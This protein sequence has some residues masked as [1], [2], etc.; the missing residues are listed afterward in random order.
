MILSSYGL[1]RFGLAV[2][3]VGANRLRVVTSAENFKLR[4]LTFFAVSPP[5]R[6]DTEYED[7]G[8]VKEEVFIAVGQCPVLL[9]M[10]LCPASY[11]TRTKTARGFKFEAVSV[12][13]CKST[14]PPLPGTLDPRHRTC[15]LLQSA[16]QPS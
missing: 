8:K 10:I 3:R 1:P 9:L 11:P 6:H 13:G 2:S 15:G 7:L 5:I 14:L 12:D 4:F 16:I